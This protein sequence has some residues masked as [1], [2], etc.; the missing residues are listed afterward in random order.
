MYYSLT[1]IL[2]TIIKNL[3]ANL[4]LGCGDLNPL[5]PPLG[6]IYIYFRPCFRGPPVECTR[7]R[8]RYD[9]N[10]FVRTLNYRAG[11]GKGERTSCTAKENIETA[12]CRCIIIV[13]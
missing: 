13:Q 4:F 5:A 3:G 2:H 8:E 10:M 9:I 11:G 7:L 1:T 12:H 6:V